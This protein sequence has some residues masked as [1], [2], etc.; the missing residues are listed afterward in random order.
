MSDIQKIASLI[1]T[2][3]ASR[4]TVLVGA[5]ISTSAGIPDF[6]SPSS[7]LY[8]KLQ[9]LHLPYPEAIFSLNYFRHTPEPF[10]AIARA[11]NPGHVVPTISHAFLALL[12]RKGLVNILFTQNIDGMEVGAG[13]GEGRV[14]AVHGSW[15][16]QRC[17]KC[18][19]VYPDELMGKAVQSGEVPY[20]E[21]E[22]CGGVVK[23]D[24]VMFGESLHVDFESLEK[25][26][27]DADMM[28]VMGTSLT[29]HPCTRLP[30]LVEKGVP[31]V[32]INREKVGDFGSREEDVCILGGCDDGVRELADAL[33][34]KDELEE[35]WKEIVAEKKAAVEGPDEGESIDVLIDRYAEKV[36]QE[37]MVS[38]G[39]KRMLE[40]HLGKKFADVLV[41]PEKKVEA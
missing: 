30:R 24:I 21:G 6:R 11:R 8:T 17:V 22:G 37:R 20:C 34:W 13:V 35:L 7:G 27:G 33:G 3:Q 19:G 28:I 5:G 26:V 2:G 16:S 31:R 18:K 12:D 1:S 4:I 39:H 36:K 25:N 14:V 32:L 40:E 9:K 15:R 41:K 38:D 10:Y 23:P 29:V